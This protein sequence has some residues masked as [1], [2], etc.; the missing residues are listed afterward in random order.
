MDPITGMFLTSLAIKGVGA[1]SGAEQT[2]RA[3][4]EAERQEDNNLSRTVA[5]NMAALSSLNEDLGD[6]TNSQPERNV[7]EKRSPS[8]K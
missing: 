2:R 3:A 7:I 1:L 6:Q 4:R 5:A 8:L